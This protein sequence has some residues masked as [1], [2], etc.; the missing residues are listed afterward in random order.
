MARGILKLSMESEKVERRVYSNGSPIR[1]STGSGTGWPKL[2]CP[3]T[4]AIFCL[5]DRRVGDAV[6]LL[7]ERTRFVRGLRA[8]VGFRQVGLEFDRDA[9]CGGYNHVKEPSREALVQKKHLRGWKRRDGRSVGLSG[10]KS[11]CG[12]G[13]MRRLRKFH[14]DDARSSLPYSA[15][16]LLGRELGDNAKTFEVSHDWK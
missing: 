15:G 1:R 2:K 7:P 13:V 5:V 6:R 8:W 12:R 4:A 16:N 11:R 10:G 14:S 9:L 3:S